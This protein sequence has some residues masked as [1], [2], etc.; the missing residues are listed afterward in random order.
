ML[1]PLT[2]KIGI[3]LSTILNLSKEMLT[4]TQEALATIINDDACQ[5]IVLD[6]GMPVRHKNVRYNCRIISY[7]RK[8]ILI[9]GV[10]LSS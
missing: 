5:D 6:I 1:H 3:N 10:L 8:I 4:R 2:D 7:N 9:V